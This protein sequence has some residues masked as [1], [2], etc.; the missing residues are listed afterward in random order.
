[1][2]ARAEPPRAPLTLLAKSSY[3]S[4]AMNRSASIS[5][6][7]SLFLLACAQSTTS[8]PA[9][10]P[11]PATTTPSAVA[12]VAA[13]PSPSVTA[14]AAPVSAAPQKPLAKSVLLLK[15]GF[16]TPESVLYDAAEDRYLVS[17]IN[18]D[19]TGVDNN[20]YI[21]ELAPDGSFKRAKFIA[22]GVDKVKLNAPKGM[23]IAKGV[24]YVAD[25]TV[26]RKFD[27]KTGA[28]KGEIPI[29]GASFLN[30]I[31][32]AG[33][34]KVY[35]TD[36]GLK[37]G[38]EGLESNGGDGVY[39]IENGKVRTLARSKD[40]LGPNGVAV[41]GP[42]VVVVTFGAEQVYKLN[43]KGEK[44]EAT[45]LP[46]GGL[47]GVIALGDELLISSWKAS[48]VFKGKLGTQFEVLIP[49]VKAP[50]DI[51]YDSK[52]KRVLVPHFTE[53]SVEVFELP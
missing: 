18:G 43:D 52:R 40:L 7:T 10:T 31:A 36:S 27:A 29:A 48:A 13:A 39:V 8:A 11:A 33:D 30:D 4:V 25:I 16:S 49:E 45:K 22:G 28:P 21:A 35:V 51:G 1:M 17:N 23:G 38:K 53:N 42:D 15:E 20:G 6:F 26:V 44:S 5:A 37:H 50:A 24:L 32:V 9:T 3:A 46:A 41:V 19:P 12:P 14:P 47:D 2:S 34:A